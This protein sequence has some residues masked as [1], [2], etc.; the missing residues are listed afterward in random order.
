MS[1]NL[2]VATGG[3]LDV[4]MGVTL[5][6]VLCVALGLG[7]AYA[8][9]GGIAG[10]ADLYKLSLVEIQVLTS[11]VLPISSHLPR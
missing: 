10:Q 2:S 7:V 11:K 6:I 5:A 1:R 4:S 9:L 3:L 8:V